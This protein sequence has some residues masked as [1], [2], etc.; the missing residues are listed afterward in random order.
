MPVVSIIYI[1]FWYYLHD[2]NIF[3]EKYLEEKTLIDIVL[4]HSSMFEKIF[5]GEMLIRTEP[6]MISFHIA[7][8]MV[9]PYAAGGYFGQYKMM[10]N[11]LKND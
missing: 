4:N 6:R 11:I 1:I 9:N 5:E 2:H 3:F 7:F 10:Q 8:M